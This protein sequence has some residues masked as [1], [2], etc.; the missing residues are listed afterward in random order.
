MPG[1]MLLSVSRKV[2]M[3]LGL[4]LLCAA[5][6]FGAP[7]RADSFILE[8]KSQPSVCDQAL[9]AKAESSF[10][11]RKESGEALA[12]AER[13][14]KEAMESCSRSTNMGNLQKRL[15][16]VEEESAQF[17]LYI[18]LFYLR[19]DGTGLLNG[20]IARLKV[21]Y[22]K[23]PGFSRRAQVLYMLGDLSAQSGN[24]SESLKYYQEVIIEF[25]RSKYAALAKQQLQRM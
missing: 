17:N 15:R 19:A 14:L 4:F 21:A 5:T 18:A 11:R 10:R 23:Y 12:R 20:A 6:L 9:L 3:M 25:P 22:E 24:E 8:L 7:Q 2:E 16:I 13:D 1:V